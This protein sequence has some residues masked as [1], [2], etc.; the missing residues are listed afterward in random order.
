M[1]QNVVN[2]LCVA[3]ISFENLL[4]GVFVS[5]VG[6]AAPFIAHNVRVGIDTINIKFIIMWL[7]YL[8]GGVLFTIW[9]RWLKTPNQKM[10][11]N[12]CLFLLLSIST[13]IHPIVTS[14]GI[15]LVN[16]FVNSLL[17]GYFKILKS[18]E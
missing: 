16:Y 3:L 17:V 1:K 6:P 7:S 14:F 10:I 5:L 11:I 12:G 4:S 18:S 13:T 8:V 15:L 9:V 2:Y